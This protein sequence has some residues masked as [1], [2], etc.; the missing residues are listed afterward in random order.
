MQRHLN[1]VNGKS[2]ENDDI[3]ESQKFVSRHLYPVTADVPS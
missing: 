1:R 2:L 3:R